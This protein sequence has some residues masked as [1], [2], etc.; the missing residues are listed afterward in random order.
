MLLPLCCQ[1]QCMHSAL[2]LVNVLTVFVACVVYVGRCNGTRWSLLW[3]YTVFVASACSYIVCTVILHVDTIASLCCQCVCT[4]FTMHI[5]CLMHTIASYVWLA[6]VLIISSVLCMRAS[7]KCWI[8]QFCSTTC[9]YPPS[10]MTGKSKWAPTHLPPMFSF[11]EQTMGGKTLF[12]HAVQR[13][14]R[15]DMHG[16]ATASVA[17]STH[18]NVQG[19]LTFFLIDGAVLKRSFLR[20]LVMER[21]IL[22]RFDP[23]SDFFNIY[24]ASGKFRIFGAICCLSA[25]FPSQLCPLLTYKPQC[26]SW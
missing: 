23:L 2:L 4:M 1:C 6:I 10:P 22:C 25:K 9:C 12:S 26:G 20:K 19:R 14:H 13:Q 3:M 24:N 5:V 8:F 11:V 17:E 7:S 16:R 21:H 18:W 15:F